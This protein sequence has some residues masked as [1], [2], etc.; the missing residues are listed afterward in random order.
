MICKKCKSIIMDSFAFCPVCGKPTKPEPRPRRHRPHGFGSVYKLKGN[1]HRPWTAVTNGEYL[2]YWETEMEAQVYLNDWVKRQTTS[3]ANYTLAQMRD[4]WM[5]SNRYKKLSKDAKNNYAAAWSR[6]Q[7]LADRKI[8]VLKTAD[9]QK[10]IQLALDQGCGYET[11][12][13]IRSLVSLLCQEAMKTDTILQNYSKG[14][15]MPERSVAA[16][17]NFSDDDIIKLFYADKDRNARIVLCIIYS[18]VRAGE[19][20]GILKANVNLRDGYMIG[21]SKTEAGIDRVI[22]IRQEIMPYIKGFMAEPGEYLITT[23]KG[24]KVDRNNFTK[25]SFYPLLDRLEIPYKD[26]AGKAVLTLGRGRHTFIAAGIE[27]GMAPEA[28]TKIVG[29]SQ[30]STSVDKYGDRL[31]IEYLKKEAQK[32]L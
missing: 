2:G 29:H 6:L 5:E 22:P 30:Y 19:L 25:R 28:L 11:C 13:K 14:L 17:R 4:Q 21:G 24:K 27:N 20:F 8:R 16:K 3:A 26:E 9:Y 18:G 32:G 1:R 10:A 7:I 31:D 15:E 12:N 23:S